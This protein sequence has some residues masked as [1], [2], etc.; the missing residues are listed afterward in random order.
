MFKFSR[1]SFAVTVIGIGSIIIAFNVG[2]SAGTYAYGGA[3][4]NQST[5]STTPPN[6][7]FS[8]IFAGQGGEDTSAPPGIDLSEVW[9][10]WHLIDS[11]YVSTT[12]STTEDT[13]ESRVDGMTAGLVASLG[14]PYTVFMPA[15]EASYFNEEISGNFVGIGVEIGMDDN[16]LTVIA[17]LKGTPAALAG[18]LSGD[19]II[20]IDGIPTA[21]M[22][23]DAAITRIRG[24]AGTTVTLTVLHNGSDTTVKIPVKRATIN[25]PTVET[26]ARADGVFVIHLYSFSANSPSLFRDALR[27]FILSGDY[28]LV[29]DLRDNPG[30]YLDAA[31][32]MASFFLPQGTV[33]AREDF[34]GN[35]SE[36]IYR[37]KGYDIFT[38]QLKMAI[39]INQGSASASEILAGALSEHHKATLIGEKSFG[40]GSVQELVPLKDGASLKVTVAKWLTPNGHS[41]IHNGLDPQITVITTKKDVEAGIDPQ[42]ERAAQFLIKGS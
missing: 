8:D 28:M 18:I 24:E 31:V 35:T 1:T 23:T 5:A 37:S 9:A 19:K 27:E 7:L 42:L 20:E 15:K 4:N 38:D 34:G 21:N 13:P 16:I 6:E 17:P 11:K 40:K 2:F 10:V 30:G 32:D 36:N 29:L 33:V 14:D 12:A 26:E 25:I 41:L 3:T 22:D 39:L